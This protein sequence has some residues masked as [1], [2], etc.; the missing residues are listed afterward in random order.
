MEQ[1]K[2]LKQV[3]G[4]NGCQ[5]LWHSLEFSCVLLSTCLFSHSG[6]AAREISRLIRLNDELAS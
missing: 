4:D 1:V 5:E 6:P 3:S 2:A